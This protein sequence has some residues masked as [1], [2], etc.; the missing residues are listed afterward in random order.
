M[1]PF[2]HWLT[3]LALF[4]TRACWKLKNCENGVEQIE[5]YEE[6]LF[7]TCQNYLYRIDQTDHY[8]VTTERLGPGTI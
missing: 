7:V 1:S 6:T 5:S 2:V 3:F 8:D 4:R